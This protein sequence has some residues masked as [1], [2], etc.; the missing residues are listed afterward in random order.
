MQNNEMSVAV[1]LYGIFMQVP[2]LGLIIWRN[3][4]G[5]SGHSPAI[6]R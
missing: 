5:R 1:L 4:P 3:L 2:A 6:L